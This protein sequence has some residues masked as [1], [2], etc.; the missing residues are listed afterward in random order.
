M[1]EVIFKYDTMD[2]LA[3]A[4]SLLKQPLGRDT[5]YEP[6]DRVHSEGG[7]NELKYRAHV[8]VISEAAFTAKVGDFSMALFGP[9]YDVKKTF[10]RAAAIRRSGD[11]VVVDYLVE[12]PPGWKHPRRF[13][14]HF[15]LGPGQ[16]ILMPV[17]VPKDKFAGNRFFNGENRELVGAM[18]TFDEW[19]ASHY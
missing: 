6:V 8:S 7:M 3:A 11:A 5:F 15:K 1:R 10:T 17:L 18:F 14:V 19:I 9:D 4:V 12:S 2:D 13:H 16:A